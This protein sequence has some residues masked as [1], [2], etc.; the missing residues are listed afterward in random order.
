MME[1]AVLSL[2]T[3]SDSPRLPRE[4]YFL[5]S[6]G[7]NQLPPAMEPVT[8]MVDENVHQ[9]LH[10]TDWPPMRAFLDW[11]QDAEPVT[12][13]MQT[14]ALEH[15]L[16]TLNDSRLESCEQIQLKLADAV[17]G[18]G[19]HL[20]LE[21]GA[22]VQ[23][24]IFS[25]AVEAYVNCAE[26]AWLRFRISAPDPKRNAY[27]NALHF[28]EW[29][30]QSLPVG[31]TTCTYLCLGALGGNAAAAA[32]LKVRKAD[33]NE[34]RNGAF[35]ALHLGQFT[36]NCVSSDEDASIA[37]FASADADMLAAVKAVTPLLN[38]GRSAM[39][40]ESSWLNWLQRQ[41]IAAE[42]HEPRPLLRDPAVILQQASRA[43]AQL[44]KAQVPSRIT[45]LRQ[46]C[47]TYGRRNG[48]V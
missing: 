20:Q 33:P 8:L 12:A 11:I 36:A 1:K 47:L 6:D 34:I 44:F 21:R 27:R 43:I 26:I 9:R 7:Q 4:L 48:L 28:L 25:T 24:A 16:S 15:V 39:F 35:D 32:T 29:R 41:V 31:S 14:V 38:G 22:C 30:A 42:L 46:A 19:T 23:E 5:T 17:L 45:E 3:S 13:T 10:R 37:V 40:I 2:G 18:G